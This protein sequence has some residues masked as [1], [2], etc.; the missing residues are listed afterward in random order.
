MSDR[1][2]SVRI[3]R[4]FWSRG[5][6]PLTGFTRGDF[7]A[8]QPRSSK[9]G[10]YASIFQAT[11]ELT[12]IFSNVHEL[13]YTQRGSRLK[14][15]LVKDYIKYID[16]FRTAIKGWNSVWG[17]LTCKLNSDLSCLP[18]SH[19]LNRNRFYEPQSDASNII[20]LPETIYKR[21]RSSSRL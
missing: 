18:I 4:A 21:L 12:Q 10:N 19:L 1:Q 15:L 9:D 14:A 2:I 7:P 16:D 11:L 17:T 20:R 6:G 8:L 13:L 3:G 5:P